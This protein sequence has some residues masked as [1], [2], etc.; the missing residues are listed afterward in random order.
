MQVDEIAK[1]RKAGG[2]R[3]MKGLAGVAAL[4]SDLDP[5]S[6]GGKLANGGGMV[7]DGSWKRG[8]SGRISGWKICPITV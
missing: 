8:R 7:C 2:V 6:T 4:A 3:L 5:V 1:R